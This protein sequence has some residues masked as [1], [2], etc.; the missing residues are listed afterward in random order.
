MT[1]RLATEGI[2]TFILVLTI[3]LVDSGGPAS[4]PVAV[5]SFLAALVYMGRHVSGAH[6]NPAVTLAVVLRG[7]ISGGEAGAY[8]AAQLAGAILAAIAAAW[9]GGQPLRIAPGAGSS[10]VQVL[11]VEILFTFALCL[12]ILNVALA[13]PT[14]GSAFSGLAIGGVVLAGM[15]AGGEISGGAFN[16]AVGLGPAIV[17][18]VGGAGLNPGVI[19]YYGLAPA[20]GS[21]LAVGVFGMQEAG[22]DGGE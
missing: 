18:F 12:V 17:G 10:I 14:E 20:L 9:I 19:A 6:Y 16:P 2:G 13:R 7:R 11:L 22:E 8:V 5:G 21:V 1:G 3:G 4:A 15:D